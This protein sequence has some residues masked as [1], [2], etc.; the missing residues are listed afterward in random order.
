MKA[1]SSK[2]NPSLL[3]FEAQ[4]RTERVALEDLRA[5]ADEPIRLPSVDHE[6]VLGLKAARRGAAELCG[7]RQERTKSSQM[8]KARKCEL[9][10]LSV[11]CAGWI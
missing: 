1:S 4:A 6:R 2:S 9:P 10:G 8:R 5:Q 7:A 3:D 11:S